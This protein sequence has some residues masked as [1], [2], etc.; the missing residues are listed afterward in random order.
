MTSRWKGRNRSPSLAAIQQRV[1]ELESLLT[2]RDQDVGSLENQLA[3]RDTTIA[4][5]EKRLSE[6]VQAVKKLRKER[7]E[8]RNKNASLVGKLAEVGRKQSLTNNSSPN[9]TRY[10]L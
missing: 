9:I 6:Q 3:L 1:L 2:A 4:D 10:I 8:L 7:D 5:L